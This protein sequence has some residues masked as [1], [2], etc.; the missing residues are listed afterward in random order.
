MKNISK[1]SL[2]SLTFPL[3]PLNEQ[4]ALVMALDGGRA[5]A[6]RLRAEATAARANAWAAF[7]GAVYAAEPEAKPEPVAAE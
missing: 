1:P 3:P 7:E 4:R 5:D 6:A 2:L